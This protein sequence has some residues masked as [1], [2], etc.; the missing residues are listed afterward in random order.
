MRRPHVIMRK[1]KR[2]LMAGLMCC[3]ISVGA[4]AQ[5]QDPKDPPPKPDPP[6]VKAEDHKNPPPDRPKGDDKKKP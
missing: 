3:V 5:K 6:K 2:I 4:L 1:L